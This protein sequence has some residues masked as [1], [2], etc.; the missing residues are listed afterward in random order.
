MSSDQVLA[1]DAPREP[2][3]GFPLGEAAV[4]RSL[5]AV[6]AADHAGLSTAVL[7]LVAVLAAGG[8]RRAL[9]HAAGQTGVLVRDRQVPADELDQALTQLADRS[10]LTLSPDGQ[11]VS[12]L[13]PVAQ[14]LRAGLARAAPLTAVC[15][16][17]ASTLEAQAD[18]LAQS[19]DEAVARDIPEQVAA[20]RENAGPAAESDKQLAVVLL[21]LRSWVLYQLIERGDSAPQVIEV[22]EPLTAEL[23]RVLG[24]DH[25]DTLNARDGLAAA[26]QAAGRAAEAIRLFEDI[27]VARERVLGPKHPDTL[28]SQNN[29]AA[30]Y[31]DAGRAAEAILLFK[32][33][34]A[35][36]E[37]LLGADHPSTLNS[38]ANLAAAYRA[39][40]RFSE[41]IPLLEQT[42]AGRERVLGADHPDVRTARDNLAAARQERDQ[43][44]ETLRLVLL[45]EP[46]PAVEQEPAEE[47]SAE[48]EPAE[49]PVPGPI[50]SSAV[51]SSDDAAPEPIAESPVALA[52]EE[53]LPA[54]PAEEE[55]PAAVTAAEA[56]DQA[57]PEP[58]PV[59]GPEPAP[60]AP[61]DISQ[62]AL[63]A[64]EPPVAVVAAE[65]RAPSAAEERLAA[66]PLSTAAPL[67]AAPRWRLGKRAIKRRPELVSVPQPEPEPQAPQDASE[68]TPL[69][70]EPPAAVAAAESSVSQAAEE[71]LAAAAVGEAAAEEPPDAPLPEEP[72]AVAA[73]V[74]PAAAP[75]EEEEEP[76][77]AAADTGDQPPPEPAPVPEREPEQDVSEPTPLADEPSAAAPPE[78]PPTPP[79]EEPAAEEPPDAPS[80]E[81]PSAEE[82]LAEE[83]AAEE[84]SAPP[85]GRWAAP[86]RDRPARRRRRVLSLVAAVVIA[87]A[88]GGVAGFLSRPHAGH[89]GHGSAASRSAGSQP[90]STASQLAAVWVAQQVAPSTIVACDPLMCS[91][92]EAQ[93][94]PAANLVVLRADATSPLGAQVVVVTPAVR[95]QFGSRM[96]SVYAPSVIAGFGSGPGQVS[97]QVV[98]KDG[99][100]AYLT[101]LQ[102]DAAD[103]KTAGAQLL[104]NK[105][106]QASAEARA[107]L[108][109]GA[110][111]S[112]LLIM[113]AALAAVHPIQVL[114]FGGPAPGA[115]PGAPLCSADLSGSGQAA[116]M[117]D[118]S[119]LRWLTSFVG[120]QLVPFAGTMSVVQEAGQPIVRVVFA[121]PSPIGL[122]SHT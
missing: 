107:Q 36:R 15:R 104:A 24:P 14:F 61:Q 18:A 37:R 74:E 116:R 13:G 83:S 93:G 43:T 22:G 2:A 96:D 44:D 28:T 56:G 122:L 118:V 105:N 12:M 86:A 106:I 51:P 55:P 7:D 85:A 23:E 94:V 91:A 119:Y 27:L 8:T 17:A 59:P 33:T 42:V 49:E 77:A 40:G 115:G 34:L 75:A 108:A 53:K 32:L 21:R 92:L 10:L 110:V 88:A 26:Y 39:A 65:P 113:L 38:G 3:D 87:L 68:P 97:V 102:Q 99:P 114:A 31:Q 79:M 50:E 78:Q 54:E 101:A 63:P 72:P 82:P 57:S 45:A 62:P 41:A 70:E 76:A 16:A 84:P 25:P 95:S 89:S 90:L 66:G 121:Q 120:T 47:Q 103:R 60:P 30:T 117:P 6:R 111:D 4:Q 98:A 67:R 71:P 80:A 58:A 81:E 29:L 64:E 48:Q 20:L 19:P 112:R 9:L 35:A 46:P 69:T 100:A 73:E 1:R 109:A 11:T 5:D 52:D